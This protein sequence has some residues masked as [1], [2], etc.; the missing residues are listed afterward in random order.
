MILRLE[1][2]KHTC[3]PETAAICLDADLHKALAALLAHGLHPENGRVGVG[4][5]HGD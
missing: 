3:V 1:S 4:A 5:D 2:L